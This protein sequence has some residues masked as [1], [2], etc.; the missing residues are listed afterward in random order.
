MPGALEM[1]FTA[2]IDFLKQFETAKVMK[3]LQT[4]DVQTVMEHPYFLAVCHHF[5]LYI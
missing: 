4:M 1:D 5:F 3:F 2:V